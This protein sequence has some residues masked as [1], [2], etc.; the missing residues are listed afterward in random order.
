MIKINLLPYR[1]ER[2][3]EIIK[4][5]VFFGA[6]PLL[7]A[8]LIIGLVWWSINAKQT[9]V[10]EDISILQKKIDQSKL[11]MKDIENYKSQ[12]EMLAKKR[13]IIKTLQ[14]NKSGPVRMIDEISTCLPGNVWLT[15]FQQKGSNLVFKGC[16]LDNI[17]VSKYMVRLENSA[18]F[19]DVELLEIKTNKSTSVKGGASLKDFRIESTVV[20]N[21]DEG[22]PSS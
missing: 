6:L 13:D 14:K 12:K 22:I 5:Q 15:E 11:K 2:K 7:A 20:Y 19:K 4:K 10:L 9:Q 17:S 21:A 1:A 8:C 16:A 3:K 18:N